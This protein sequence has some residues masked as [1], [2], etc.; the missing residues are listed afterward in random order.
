VANHGTGTGWSNSYVG[1]A[2]WS[3]WYVESDYWI[4]NGVYRGSGT[5]LPATDWRT[6]YGFKVNNNNGSNAPI[7][8]SAIWLGP[9]TYPSANGTTI[10]YVEVAG[11]GDTHGV[12]LDEGIESQQSE[13]VVIEY[14]Y[15]HDTGD[16]NI[17]LDA[18][19]SATVEYN[20][21]MNDQSTPSEHGE[22]IAIRGAAASGYTIAFNYLENEGGTAYI[23]TPEYDG[24]AAI[25]YIY[26]NV[27]FA[28]TNEWYGNAG[29][30][31]GCTT[32]A[33]ASGGDTVYSGCTYNPPPSGVA[34]SSFVG[35]HM[36]VSG[37]SNSANNTPG[38]ITGTPW[39]IVAASSTSLTL[40]NASGVAATGQSCSFGIQEGL[41]YAAI[42]FF[43]GSTSEIFQEID[44]W[45]NTFYQLS[46]AGTGSATACDFLNS[47]PRTVNILRFQ[48]NLFANCSTVS[49][50]SADGGTLTE[51]HNSFFNA[52]SG[53]TGTGDQIVAS[54]S[55]FVAAASNNFALEFDTALWTALGS[56]Y[57]TD[58]LGRAR[59]S[60]RG[61]F[62]MGL[63][64]VLLPLNLSL[65]A[66]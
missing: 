30:L 50:P 53:Y 41:S 54:G 42:N 20:W 49:F 6:G 45:N 39:T 23:G 59:T 33:N 63:G 36:Y 31:F 17:I 1:Q 13:G 61:A 18:G 64:T 5:G 66:H 14:N 2:V 24:N 52:G 9:N 34:A 51:D 35:A 4:F 25:Y 48:N 58:I 28:N 55:P 27:F 12:Q 15:V 65:S 37:C 32:V 46:P 60:S 44:F 26:G 3:S 7:G 47:N 10:E 38:G 62:Q 57:N 43:S 8:G 29:G 22:G 16:C 56:P 11:S 40:S 19:T 21:L